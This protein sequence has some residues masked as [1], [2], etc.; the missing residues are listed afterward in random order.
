MN[1]YSRSLMLRAH[2][3]AAIAGELNGNVL[4]P[5]PIRQ[6]PQCL[7]G[8]TVTTS[9]RLQAVLGLCALTEVYFRR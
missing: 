5:S 9:S 4:Y 6:L 2:D 8:Q 3:V 1:I 7:T